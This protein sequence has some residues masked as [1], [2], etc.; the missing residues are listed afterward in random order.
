MK[1]LF[2]SLLLIALSVWIGFLIHQDSGYVMIAYNGYTAEASLWVMII[3][4]V[5][6]FG[7]LYFAIRF[8][9]HTSGLSAR[10]QKWDKRRKS[11]RARNLTNQGL[12]DLAEG[13]WQEAQK[14]LTK[15]AKD[16]PNPLINYLASARAAHF[17]KDY[18]A[19]DEHLRKAH[20]STQGSEVAVGLTQATL[21]IESKQW[22]QAL[23]T[24][25]HLNQ[26]SP[27]HRFILKLLCNVHLE[28]NDWSIL[29]K[30]LPQLRKLN[31]FDEPELE[32]IDKQIH[33][34]LLNEASKSHNL[35]KLYTEWENFPKKW[36]QDPR[37]LTLYTGYLIN[38]HDY[39]QAAELISKF[40]KKQWDVD[41][42]NNYGLAL[43]ENLNAQIATAEE[44]LEKHPGEPELLLCI[45]RLSLKANF[46]GQAEHM[47]S[48][49][50]ATAALPEAYTALGQV[51]EKL[52]KP[53]KAL[54]MYK[55]ALELNKKMS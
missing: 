10:Y 44:W 48:A 33:L 32:H 6:V 27:N 53:E 42:V 37:A 23:A 25:N 31:I 46:L 55:K 17:V 21:Q 35:N 54:D 29:Q 3:C 50:V 30:L 15:A 22:E 12:C 5:I 24:L 26:I 34:G 39:Q 13:N 47:L 38:A 40:L 52:E 45:G 41:L 7:L 8:F 1:K 20:L 36:R 4:L 19:R 14:N 28:L 2:I 9:K 18:H 51:L 43:T 49:C 11:E 16:H